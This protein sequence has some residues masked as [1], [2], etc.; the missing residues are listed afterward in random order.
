MPRKPK[1]VHPLR[2]VRE[3]A[4]KSQPEFAKL[5]G[6]SGSYIQ[7]VELGQRKMSDELA[8]AIML[9][10]GIDRA[11]LGREIPKSLIGS[12]KAWFVL[13]SF[14]GSEENIRQGLAELFQQYTEVQK[15]REPRE[16]LRR[17]VD[18]WQNSVIPGWEFWKVRDALQRKLDLLLEAAE[19]EK[20]KHFAVA[21]S[22]SRWIEETV[23]D[24]RLQAMIQHVL[25]SRREENEGWP[26][27]ME[28]LADSFKLRNSTNER[29][30]R[31]R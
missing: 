22:L 26:A 1:F 2:I 24:F 9:R 29:S 4:G 7:A 23:R 3:A 8:D 28:T 13:R 31:R 10:F 21:M 18:F 14:R 12:G 11:S 25:K 16:R 17:C 6:V 19:L 15:V 27:F 5:F 30:R 20:K